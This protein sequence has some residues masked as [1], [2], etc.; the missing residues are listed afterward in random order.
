MTPSERI[1]ENVVR[2]VAAPILGLIAAAYATILLAVVLS[3]LAIPASQP[4]LR[5]GS[6]AFGQLAIGFTFVFSGA[7]IAPKGWRLGTA[8]GLI[9]CG[10]ALYFYLQSYSSDERRAWYVVPFIAGG[11]LAAV[12][13]RLRGHAKS[14]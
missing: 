4:L 12:V 5:F 6:W 14:G 11:L 8:F 3:L 1:T 9:G 13:L 7:L 2:V 10:I